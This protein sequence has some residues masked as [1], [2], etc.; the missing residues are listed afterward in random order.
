MVDLL[1][2]G[3]FEVASI[4]RW[5]HFSGIHIREG[6]HCS[7]RLSL[8]SI[9]PPPPPSYLPFPWWREPG[10]EASVSMETIKSPPLVYTKQTPLIHE[11]GP[12][13]SYP[14]PTGQ[15]TCMQVSDHIGNQS[16]TIFI[17]AE[18]SFNDIHSP[19]VLC[20]PT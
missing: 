14:L 5:P 19:W 3:H 4:E 16:L 8:Q 18:S 12:Q 13:Y 17:A 15:F 10:G 9:K 11:C 6:V 20:L 7:N 2:L 1:I